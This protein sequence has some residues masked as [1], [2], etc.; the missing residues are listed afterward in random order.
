MKKY[1]A[2]CLLSGI[3]LLSAFLNLWNIWN[4]GFS[5]TFYAAAVRSMLDNPHLLFFNSFDPAGFVTVDKPPVGLWVQVTFAAV[6]GFSGWALVLP[7]AL[8]GIGS[9]FLVYVIVSRPFGKAAGLAGALALA[10]TPIFVA[11]SRNGT[12]DSQLIFVILLALWAALKATRERS[13]PW[14]LVSVVLVG[15]GFNIKMI[16]AFIVVPAILAIYL[17]GAEIPVK[18]RIVHLILAIAVLLAVSLSWAVAVDMIPANE[19]PFIGGSG[20][21]TV[22]GL[23]VNYNGLHRLENGGMGSMSGGGAG[24]SPGGNEGIAG[25]QEA[26]SG[27]PGDQPGG[28]TGASRADRSAR[29]DAAM[30]GMTPPGTGGTAAG[31]VQQYGGAPGGGGMGGDTGSPGVLRLAGEGLAGQLS[32]LI[33][34]ALIGLLAWWRRPATLT[35]DGLKEAG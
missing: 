21:N 29:G 20:D 1:P 8:A 6:L 14:L 24:F 32:W 26:G 4:Q 5:N 18:K 33:P 28:S 10:I 9:V 2:E 25:P 17:L 11:V 34:F 23:I 3:L 31:S 27:M 35:V 12:M 13:L 16:Q 19:R 22:L 7:Q 15:I 30:S